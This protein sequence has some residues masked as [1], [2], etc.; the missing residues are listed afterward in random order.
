MIIMADKDREKRVC[1]QQGLK[2]IFSHLA[3]WSLRKCPGMSQLSKAIGHWWPWLSHFLL[4]VHFLL[5]RFQN[6]QGD[7]GVLTDATISCFRHAGFHCLSAWQCGKHLG[8][9]KQTN[10]QTASSSWQLANYATKARWLSMQW[11]HLI[12]KRDNAIHWFTFLILN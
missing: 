1:C 11:I 12:P 2:K 7:L 9:K 8:T 10:K 5:S 3:Y 4:P 6:R